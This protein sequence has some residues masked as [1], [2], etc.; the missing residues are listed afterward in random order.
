MAAVEFSKFYILLNAVKNGDSE[1][2]KELEEMLKS[3]EASSD[4]ESA[5]HEL[6]QKYIYVGINEL[7]EYAGTKD[8]KAIG[9]IEKEQWED[10]KNERKSELPPHL[11][12][13]MIS[14]AKENNL[15]KEI[16]K[17][18]ELPKRD[19]EK[20]LMNMARYITEGIIDAI[21]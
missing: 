10:I 9:D 20:N 11:A 14:Y 17:K 18:W 7:Y 1:K 12:N 15:S 2:R 13:T 19:I 16:S 4:C 3:F 6:G 8:L 21:D 5:L